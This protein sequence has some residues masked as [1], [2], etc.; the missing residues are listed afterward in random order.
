M[1]EKSKLLGANWK[2]VDDYLKKETAD[3]TKLAV[4]EADKVFI[5][6]V[7]KKGYKVVSL[8]DKI[9]LAVKEMK[10][11][12]SFLKARDKVL[13]FRNELGFD[14]EDPYTGGEIIE[15]YKQGI[16]DLL[17]GVIDGKKYQSLKY[18]F[19]KPYFLFYSNKKSIYRGLVYFIFLILF[20][21]FIADTQLGKNLFDSIIDKIHLII[22]IILVI[23]FI[24]FALAFFI[25]LSIIFIE[26][27]TKRK[28]VKKEI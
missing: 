23:V 25:T 11:P 8:E 4:L 24:I 15:T 10:N 19:W 28:A 6:T 16:E 21:L 17:F 2:I 1:I 22:R 13:K 7:R 26:S 9:F 14:L 27:R 18:R 20:L 5:D 3:G 12:D